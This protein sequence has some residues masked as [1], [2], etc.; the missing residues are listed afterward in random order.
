[1]KKLLIGL[2]LL[3]A[4][5]CG[6]KAIK[7]DVDICDTVRKMPLPEQTITY[8]DN[9]YNEFMYSV[10]LEISWK[11][12]LGEN[13]ACAYLNVLRNDKAWNLMGK[14]CADFRD[15]GLYICE[16]ACAFNADGEVV[17]RSERCEKVTK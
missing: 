14:Y 1:M 15:D 2:A 3:L 13:P 9:E 7:K 8:D 17:G 4:M 11:M 5:G 12:N 16:K 10:G 6:G